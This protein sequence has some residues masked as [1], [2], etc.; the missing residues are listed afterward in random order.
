MYLKGALEVALSVEEEGVP[1]G[2][3]GMGD[4]STFSFCCWLDFFEHRDSE[5]RFSNVEKQD[6]NLNLSVLSKWT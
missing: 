6:F 4:N 2:N 1:G 5:C 3:R